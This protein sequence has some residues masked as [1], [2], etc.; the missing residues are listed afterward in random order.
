MLN[1]EN[2]VMDDGSPED[3]PQIQEKAYEQPD[4]TAIEH[5]E[6]LLT[7]EPDTTYPMDEATAADSLVLESSPIEPHYAEDRDYF[8]VLRDMQQGQWER[9][10]P[11]L[12]ALQARYPNTTELDSLLQ[13]ATFRSNLEA[14]WG[15]KVKGAR[16]IRLPVKSLMSAIP[17][18]VIVFLL[19]GGTIFY[20]RIQRVNA[21]SE[22]Q[23]EILQQAQSALSA[24]Q[25]REALD[26]FESV[27]A[28]NPKN[29]D[30]LKGQNETKRQ[31]KL[32][33]DYQLAIDRIES[34]NLQQALELLA[35][36]QVEAPGYRDVATRIEEIKSQTGAPRLFEEAE[37]AFTN[38][39]WL[40]A[41][42]QY[43]DL[44]TL[45]NRY[46]PDLVEDRLSTSYLKAG[47]QIV[48]V[49][50]GDSTMLQQA[51]EYFRR[52]LQ[53]NANDRSAKAESELLEAFLS[54]E[55][56]V[57]QESYEQ[58][59][60]MLNNIYTER[61]EY[62]GGYAAELL[63]RAYVG[64][65]ERAVQQGNLER[66]QAA[67]QRAIGLGFDV[68]GAANQRLDEISAL[69]NPAPAPVA[70]PVVVAPVVNSA[71]AASVEPTPPPDPLALYRGWIAFRTNRNGGELFYIMRPD[72]SEQ[73]PAPM[74]LVQLMNDL[75]Q[76]QQ[77]SPDGQQFVYVQHVS[78]QASTNIF[79]VRADLPATWDRD[80]MLTDYFGTEYDPIWS[81]DGRTIAFV[82]NHT[83]ND[84]IWT[85]DADGGSHRQLTSNDW[86]WDKHPSFSPDGTQITF[87]SNSSGT[88]QI[89][90]MNADG[91]N[92]RNISN[93]SS[94]DWAPVWIR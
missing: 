40:T 87:Y 26:L 31:M 59:A 79:K 11:M 54:A 72:G 58:G 18:A 77:W 17:V 60:E 69:L 41:I 90:V 82:S 5:K 70:A 57:Q 12:R 1:D 43:E 38:N 66:A 3:Y 71:P 50:P 88:R 46:E 91:G 68:N 23:Q 9:V 78:D 21:L 8:E 22:Q 61:P 36:L 73:Q 33:N 42:V 49:R 85:M 64:L 48:S 13:E 83:G 93:N 75:H 15:D 55:N 19:I 56:L 6:S 53:L 63:F 47:Q 7:E 24:S 81:P 65:G 25:Y 74:D 2:S 45:D 27:L 76:Q 62:F 44:R 20:S 39:L 32:A 16:S 86:E 89:W 51:E 29:E 92:Q 52:S 14:N 80:I 28:E 30:A 10:I 35:A 37:F 67:Y 84:E 34:G 4:G 94:E